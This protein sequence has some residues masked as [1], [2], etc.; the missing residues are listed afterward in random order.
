MFSIKRVPLLKLLDYNSISKYTEE[1]VRRY[2]IVTPHI[3]EK[4]GA[5]SGGNIQRLILARELER[6]PKILIA[7]EPTAGLDI[8]AT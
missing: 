1:L 2:E 3:R 8:K 4:A 6:L 7:E 5:L